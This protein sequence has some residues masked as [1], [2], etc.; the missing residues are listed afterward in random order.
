M[1]NTVADD[2]NT[3]NQLLAQLG[4]GATTLSASSTVSDY[5]NALNSVFATVKQE[6]DTAVQTAAAGDAV[7]GTNYAAQIQAQEN[8]IITLY[9]S[10]LASVGNVNTGLTLDVALGGTSTG[11]GGTSTG[12]TTGGTTTGGTTTGGTTTGGTTPGGT[13]GTTPAPLPISSYV[14]P[15]PPS[16]DGV[17]IF[18]DTPMLL[19]ETDYTVPAAA[20][21]TR[22]GTS[23]TFVSPEISSDWTKVGTLSYPDVTSA[24]TVAYEGFIDAAKQLVG[25]AIKDEP[26][27]TAAVA[28]SDA[29]DVGVAMNGTL[30]GTIQLMSDLTKVLNGT[31]T[32]ADWLAKQEAFS[33]REDSKYQGLAAASLT[34]K[35]PVV[36]WVLSPIVDKLHGVS[37]ELQTT[38]SYQ[39]RATL[40]TTIPG[41]PKSNVVIGG[42]LHNNIQL[43]GGTSAAAGGDGG[44]TFTVGVGNDLIIGG[45]G[46]DKVV[47]PATR[48][49]YTLKTNTDGTLAVST[50]KTGV[51][52]TDTVVNIERLQ[53]SDGTFA[54]DTGAGQ[55]A[56]EAYRIYQAAFGRTPDSV[57]LKYWIG[58]MDGGASLSDIAGGFIGS[59]EFQ[60]AYG[61]APSNADLVSKFYQNVLGRQ[62]DPGGYTYWV[63]VLNGGGA[64]SDVLAAFAES[65]ENQAKVLGVI[66][67]GIW[68]G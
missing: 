21:F 34:S 55:I 29:R 20:A 47:L 25:E 17:R 63:G 39:L 42:A 18:G 35:I 26:W 58:V 46:L 14:A 66:E 9:Q 31:M 64:H 10:A 44:N 36:G 65:G 30:N 23:A 43:G 68:L 60:K 56:G 28:A 11:G 40:D 22:V 1:A 50:S 41:G 2:L 4:Q 3:L 32:E 62:P 57:G 12:G 38:N 6:M 48:A 24:A 45:K 59:P 19:R 52:G 15:L 5:V 53:F 67:H 27:G 7:L 8:Q 16:G 61:A 13:G 49:D 51:A 33:Q 37:M 54:L